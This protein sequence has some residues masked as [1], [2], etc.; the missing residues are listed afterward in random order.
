MKQVWT[1]KCAVQNAS[2]C[3][4]SILLTLKKN[5]GH[6]QGSWIF[7]IKKLILDYYY[8]LK[9][10]SCVFISNFH[11]SP[12]PL[13]RDINCIVNNKLINNKFRFSI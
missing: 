4:Y 11:H 10:R 8:L 12:P 7:L 2:G 6:S 9:V 3:Q 1:Q 13:P 5:H